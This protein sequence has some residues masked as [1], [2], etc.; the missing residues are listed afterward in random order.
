MG[1][2]GLK[3]CLRLSPVT[4]IKAGFVTLQLRFLHCDLVKEREALGYGWKKIMFGLKYPV[5]VALYQQEMQHCLGKNQP[6]FVALSRQ[7]M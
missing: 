3:A 7:K 6:L 1:T 5:L 2:D 4:R